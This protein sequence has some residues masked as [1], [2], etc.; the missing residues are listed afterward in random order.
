MEA[1]WQAS[2]AKHYHANIMIYFLCTA[3][4]YYVLFPECRFIRNLMWY[5]SWT[6]IM[7]LREWG[8]LCVVV[9]MTFTWSICIC[10]PDFCQ[11]LIIEQTG[12]IPCFESSTSVFLHVSILVSLAVKI[13]HEFPH[14]VIKC[15]PCSRGHDED[16]HQSF[17]WDKTGVFCFL[18]GC[19]ERSA[20]G[21]GNAKSRVATMMT[22]RF[23]PTAMQRGC[24]SSFYIPDGAMAS[25]LG[26]FT[27]LTPECNSS[28]TF[29]KEAN[30]IL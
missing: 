9:I 14:P 12:G 11:M 4:I 8:K 20:G 28:E 24:S 30:N 3:G 13:Y 27:S 29:W 23:I 6:H 17:P 10:S 16:F 5:G 7:G 22:I 25:G 15:M 19:S 2:K 1:K 18:Q 21:G 26:F